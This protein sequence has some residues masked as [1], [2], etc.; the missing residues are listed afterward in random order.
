MVD[1]RFSARALSKLS[2]TPPRGASDAGVDE[3][4]RK[5]HQRVL[6]TVVAV[7]DELPVADIAGKDRVVQCRQDELGVRTRAAV[8]A[9][10]LWIT[11][12]T[13]SVSVRRPL[14]QPTTF[15]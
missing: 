6:T 8:P 2:P 14:S 3:A 5:P 9:D 12:R 11:D 15:G 1:H 7:M 4:L 10:D 13:S